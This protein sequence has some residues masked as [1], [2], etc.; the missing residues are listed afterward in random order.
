V[1]GLALLAKK[2]LFRPHMEKLGEAGFSVSPGASYYAV[3]QQGQ[4]IG[5]ASSTIDT[6]DGGSR[7]TTTSWRI[8]RSAVELHRAT[9]RTEVEL[10]RALRVSRFKMQVDAGLT[11][12]DASG[13]VLGDT[14]LWWPCAARTTQ[15]DTHRVRLDGRSCSRRSCRSRSPSASRRRRARGSSL[16]VFD[17]IALAPRQMHVTIDAESVFVV[18]DSSVF[19]A[20]KSRW[21]GRPDT[22]RAWRLATDSATGRVGVSRL[23]RR[24]G[25]ARARDA[26]AG[27]TLE[28][29]PYEVAFENWK[30]D[31]GKR[32]GGRGRPRHL[33]DDGDR[34]EQ[35]AAREH[36]RRSRV[37]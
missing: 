29:R 8:C 13:Q 3:L 15:V 35:A 12:I 33:R 2:E 20:Q 30:A 25:A 26:A 18:P 4:Q 28:R 17:P 32:A 22:V 31:A 24:A 5:F 6:T 11:P 9:A 36:R 7:C 27:M 23:G 19:D 34:G 14:L 1:G 37:R 10:T 21:T 16:P